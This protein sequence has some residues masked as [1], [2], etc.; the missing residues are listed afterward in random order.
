LDQ[1][2]GPRQGY[3]DRDRLARSFPNRG[4]VL[5]S[6]Q[7]R[8]GHGRA[9]VWK[10]TLGDEYRVQKGLSQVGRLDTPFGGD[11]SVKSTERNDI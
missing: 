3:P 2:S 10:G 7:L 4:K 8:P 1:P 5:R 11:L 9:S 6:Y